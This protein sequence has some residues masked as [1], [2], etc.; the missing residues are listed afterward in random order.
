MK[1]ENA[2]F[3]F[4]YVVHENIFNRLK[5]TIQ[6]LVTFVYNSLAHLNIFSVRDFGSN[7]DRMTA[8]RL[9]QWSTVLYMIVFVIGIAIL[10]L[11]IMFQAETFTKTFN[12]PSLD[13]YKD[14]FQ[15]YEDQLK[16]SCSS[17]PSINDRF[18]KVEAILH[19]VSR[20]NYT[21]RI[22]I[23]CQTEMR[24]PKKKTYFNRIRIKYGFKQNL[25]HSISFFQSREGGLF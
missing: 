4:V 16:C 9:G 7:I 24:L 2:I 20:I 13:L 18:I 19:D 12:K 17:I 14:L 8:K 10:T 15:Q 21:N 22:K 1:I 5:S 11:Y 23:K 25:T 3:I 6:K